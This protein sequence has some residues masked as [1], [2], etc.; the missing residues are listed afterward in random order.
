VKTAIKH[1]FSPNKVISGT[2]FLAL[3]AIQAGAALALWTFGVSSLIPTPAAIARA[4]V[5][6]MF[7]GDLASELAASTTLACEAVAITFA[8]SLAVSYA[9]VLPFFRPLGQVVSKMRFL[10]LVG[11]S[12]VFT[13]LVSGGHGLKLW[14]LVFGMTVF[15]VTSMVEEIANI[16][17][18]EF[19]H[20]RTLGMGE[21]RVVWEVIILGRLDR[22]FEILRQNFAVAWMMITMVEGISRAEGGVGAM[23][24]SQN[25]H[26]RLDAVFAIQITI[27]ALGIG[28]DYLFG[29][30]KGFLF[31]YSTLTTEVR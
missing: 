25:K 6:M 4:W 12:F 20:A 24:L 10:S 2:T 3:C 29:V 19:S 27:F 26:F 17:K 8:I 30:T 11:L 18:N 9:T 31:P 14:L 21:W 1:C 22:A 16:P 13:L 28:I 5:D 23:L 7:R 15:Y